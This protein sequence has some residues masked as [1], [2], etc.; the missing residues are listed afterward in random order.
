MGAS[1]LGLPKSIYYSKA[2]RA[3]AIG[4][5]LFRLGSGDLDP[6]DMDIS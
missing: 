3:G 2:E 6:G 5:P 1:L 4:L